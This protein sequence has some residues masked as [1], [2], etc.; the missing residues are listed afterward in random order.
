VASHGANVSG[1]IAA[2]AETIGDFNY[3]GGVAPQVRL[4]QAQSDPS[5]DIDDE[6]ADTG[7]EPG[8]EASPSSLL[9]P[10]SEDLF[11]GA[12]TTLYR[13]APRLRVINN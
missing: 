5:E 13:S 10:G 6:G 7:E 4:F 12:L 2:R 11:H 8:A 1:I 9:Q 3:R